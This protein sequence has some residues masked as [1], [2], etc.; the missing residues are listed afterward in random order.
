M[1]ET[2][3]TQTTL[4]PVKKTD[5]GAIAGSTIIIVLLIIAGWYF[6]SELEKINADLDD[7][8]NPKIMAPVEKRPTPESV[9]KELS[10]N[11]FDA[12]Q[13]DIEGIEGEFETTTETNTPTETQ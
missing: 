8:N 3:Q 12:I 5:I 6:Y 1:N 2:Q 9:E 10:N 4:T 11:P 13:T 7:V